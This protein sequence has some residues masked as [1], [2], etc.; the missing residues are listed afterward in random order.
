MASAVSTA[1]TSAAVG[2]GVPGGVPSAARNWRISSSVKLI[3]ATTT[4]LALPGD[5]PD[6]YI[7][8]KY[9][10]PP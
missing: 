5:R 8:A 3:Q 1:R 9:F 2:S 10:Y 6:G 4:T 7:N